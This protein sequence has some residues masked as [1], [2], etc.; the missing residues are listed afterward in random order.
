MGNFLSQKAE[1]ANM[2]AHS[3]NKIT[4]EAF[5]EDKQNSGLACSVSKKTSGSFSNERLHLN[6]NLGM[7]DHPGRTWPSWPFQWIPIENSE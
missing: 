5:K 1:N 7:M 2:F 4:V 6:L 3:L